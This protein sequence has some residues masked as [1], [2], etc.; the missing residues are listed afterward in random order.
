MFPPKK[1]THKGDVHMALTEQEIEQIT[2]EIE[3]F[4]AKA[5]Q[6]V[7]SSP[8]LSAHY[9]RLYTVSKK[10]LKGFDRIKRALEDKAYRESRKNARAGKP[11]PSSS[12]SSGTAKSKSA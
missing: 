7:T 6:H 5:T 1:E 12:T 3:D 9:N 11:S 2:K 8:S 10:S 4:K